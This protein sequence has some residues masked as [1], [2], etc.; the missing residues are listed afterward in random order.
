M[1]IRSDQLEVGSGKNPEMVMM[2]DLEVTVRSQREEQHN[3]EHK[4]D[5]HGVCMQHVEIRGL[6]YSRASRRLT[7]TW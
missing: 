1:G 3:Q 5:H 6:A 7:S 2:R 4:K